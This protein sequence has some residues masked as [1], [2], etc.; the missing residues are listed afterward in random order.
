[1]D[2]KLTGRALGTMWLGMLLISLGCATSTGC[3][4]ADS[5]ADGPQVWLAG[6]DGPVRILVE[7]ASRVDEQARG[8]MHRQQMPEDR[9]MIFIYS[10]EALHGFWMK[11]TYIPLDMLFI[12]SNRRIVGAVENA[13][14]LTTTRRQV[15]AP[16][17]YVLEIN[18][19][20]M[21]KLGVIE[22]SEVRFENLSR[23]IPE[24]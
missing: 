24:D 17:K 8:L 21:K 20:L 7:V 15:N 11:N 18:G 1:M 16:S 14:P 4:S 19:G 9:G 12:G 3:K 22:G 23:W 5:H 10:T 2:R 6:R 13:E